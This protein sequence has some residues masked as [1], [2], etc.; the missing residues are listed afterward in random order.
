M[1]VARAPTAKRAAVEAAVLRATEDLLAE[2][3]SYADLNVERIAT[4]RRA[5]RAPPSTS[6][7]ATSASC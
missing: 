3:T 7:S 6:T 5:S 2:G 4:P 1:A